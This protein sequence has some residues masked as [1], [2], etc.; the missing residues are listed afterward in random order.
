MLSQACLVDLMFSEQAEISAFNASF[1][2]CKEISGNLIINVDRIWNLDG[3]ER[4]EKIG[5]D[6]IIEGNNIR[7]LQGLKSLREVGGDFRIS[8]TKHLVSLD[9][10][11]SLRS[12]GENLILGGNE[13][14]V[15]L[16]VL[17]NLELIEGDMRIFN[18]ELLASLEGLENIDVDQLDFLLISGNPNLSFCGLSSICSFLH[19][20]I[21]HNILLNG[22]G[23]NSLADI[24]DYCTSTP[25]LWPSSNLNLTSQ[26]EVDALIQIQDQCINFEGEINISGDIH[27]IS[28]LD[29]F[30][31]GLNSI[32]IQATQIEEIT[33]FNQITHVDFI[34]INSNDSLKLIEGFDSLK[35]ANS[36]SISFSSG[37]EELKG[38]NQ[39]ENLN[40]LTIEHSFVEDSSAISGFEKLSAIGDNFVLH[41]NDFQTFNAFNNLKG[42]GNNFIF[43]EN[44]KLVHLNG[45]DSLKFIEGRFALV[46]ND[47][48]YQIDIVNIDNIGRQISIGENHQLPNLHFLSG[49]THLNDDVNIWNNASLV[50]LFNQN[51][52][53]H[54]HWIRLADSPLLV[55]L[56]G[57]NNLDT[58]DQEFILEE[59]NIL[60]LTDLNNLKKV[61][62]D[63]RLFSLDEIENFNGLELLTD[64]EGHL[65]VIRNDKLTSLEGL[66][67][68]ERVR[69]LEIRANPVL[70]DISVLNDLHII[71]HRQPS[72]N[73]LRIRD[74]SSLEF[75][76]LE[77]FCNVVQNPM[78]SVDIA[79]NKSGCSDEEQFL[80]NC[81]GGIG[82]ISELKYDTCYSSQTVEISSE[83]DNLHKAINFVDE[84]GEIICTLIPNGNELG[85]VS[86]DVFLSSDLRF[87]DRY[88]ANRDIFF[89]TEFK[90]QFEV[91]LW[92][93]YTKEEIEALSEAAM[94][95]K[96]FLG[97]PTVSSS[98]ACVEQWPDS[99]D[100]ITYFHNTLPFGT[101]SM[102]VLEV[103]ELEAFY[104]FETFTIP[105]EFTFF[106]GVN[107]RGEAHLFWQTASEINNDYFEIQRSDDGVHFATRGQVKGSG[108]TTAEI[109]YSFV[110]RLPTKG[111]NYYRLKQVD[112]DGSSEFSDIISIHYKEE[113]VS[114]IFPNPVGSTL[115][116]TNAD[117]KTVSIFDITGRLLMKEATVEDQLNIDGIKSGIYLLKMELNDQSSY[118]KF[119]KL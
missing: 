104:L 61:G 103:D 112:F 2:K 84:D 13:N 56:N 40:W 54:A 1:P 87:A 47:L 102:T 17:F 27:D 74:N 22:D 63:F 48:L 66:G 37:L 78:H 101:D 75:C 49:I 45:L 90:N 113:Q 23:C 51:K 26:A 65:D 79:N 50:S 19:T 53:E 105:V 60:D 94:F 11:D 72:G 108:T 30:K 80:W 89:N 39:L 68:L 81:F 93:L 64:V 95:S 29:F 15:S 10:L 119:T 14:L 85:E 111:N 52:L 76:D 43:T 7:D 46:N 55:D 110:D 114:L 8:N 16:E 115:N 3:L 92:L 62:S 18:N 28:G 34:H 58:I 41:N 71:G 91:Y 116:F 25:C 57:F 109:D 117:A 32:M 5:G 88:Y 33:N 82:Q 24:R 97:M 77:S 4:L 42:I 67:S 20:G 9:G 6:L 31:E 70:E 38:F 100:Y 44:T 99:I 118:Q 98:N 73:E 21:N 107:K 69:S 35:T 59:L 83:Q 86:V 96:Q 36:I 12:I 106:Q